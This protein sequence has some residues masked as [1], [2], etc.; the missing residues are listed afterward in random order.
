ME[1]L[2]FPDTECRI[3]RWQCATRPGQCTPVCTIPFCSMSLTVSVPLSVP[4][5]LAPCHWRSV[6]PFLYHS[7]LLHVTDGQCTPVC[8]IPPCSMSL[9]VYNLSNNQQP[10][11]K[12]APAAT[13]PSV[14]M[15]HLTNYTTNFEKICSCANYTTHN[16]I[17]TIIIT[18]LSHTVPTVTY[19]PHYRDIDLSL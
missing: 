14:R 11:F 5:H 12:P 17:N 2:Q 19:S 1:A 8:T 7:T 3:C 18:P 6:Y 15:F 10:V 9:T 4:F 16:C 13:C